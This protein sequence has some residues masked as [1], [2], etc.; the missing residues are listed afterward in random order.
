V[1]ETPTGKARPLT[2]RERQLLAA[3]LDCVAEPEA[4][5][6]R[7]QLDVALAR[8]GCPCGCGSIDIVLASD[9]TTRSVRTGAGVLVEGDVLDERGQAV[10]GLMLFLNDG[11]L[12]DVEVWSV[13]DPLDL[14]SIDRAHLRA[15]S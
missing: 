8:P 5:V 13:G 1:H 10:G 12:H 6:L 9:N 4:S 11:M 14:P 15:T 3:M 2:D 7:A